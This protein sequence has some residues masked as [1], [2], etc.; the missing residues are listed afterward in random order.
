MEQPTTE[1]C[2]HIVISGRVTGVGY[3]FWFSRR[4]EE[5]GLKGYVRN[6]FDGKV[7][8][9]VCGEQGAVDQIVQEA[10]SGSRWSKPT[11]VKVAR[12]PRQNFTQFQIR[13]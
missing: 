8:A 13:A 11:H 5:L 1:K 4:S 7:E 6:R 2:V 3:R 12:T 10:W 9:H